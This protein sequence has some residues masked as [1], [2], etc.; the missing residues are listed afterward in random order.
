MAIDVAT[1]RQIPLF[2]ALS[3]QDLAKVAAMMVDSSLSVATSSCSKVTQ[4]EDCIM[5]IRGW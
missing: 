3:Q 1:L 4:V 2:A 5:C